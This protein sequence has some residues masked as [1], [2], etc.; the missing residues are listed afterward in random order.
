VTKRLP[1][2][3]NRTLF[4]RR[5][6]ALPLLRFSS[7][8]PGRSF[9]LSLCHSVTLSLF[10]CASAL[11]AEPPAPAAGDAGTYEI[12][13][14]RPQKVGQAYRISAVTHQLQLV[15]IVGA[16]GTDNKRDEFYGVLEAGVK[17]LATDAR[18]QPTSLSLT[19]AKCLKKVRDTEKVLVAPGAVVTASV[20]GD[21]SAFT[22]DGKPADAETTMIL[23]MMVPMASEHPTDDDIFGT[24]RRVKVADQWPMNSDLA[25][26][27]LAKD[28]PGLRKEDV[29]GTVTL[30]AASKPADKTAA[31]TADADVIEIA[32]EMTV[33]NVKPPAARGVTVEKA[34][35]QMKFSGK[36]PADPARLPLE[37]SHTQ[38]SRVVAKAQAV[39]KAT[40][41]TVET[42]TERTTTV[43]YSP[44]GQ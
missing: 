10:L 42:T 35:I 30:V 25:A 34:D 4:L 3:S 43:A 14:T 2:R 16:D 33:V 26:S 40:V 28:S 21:K 39:A 12:R 5:L 15:T 44:A 18:S 7:P 13:L 20:K 27:D 32:A 31:K 29:A 22:I 1:S 6:A 11:A 38:T 36:Y 37:L 8:P 41:L 23:G 19:V 17:V 24:R 9:S